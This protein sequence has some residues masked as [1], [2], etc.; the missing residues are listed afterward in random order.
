MDGPRKFKSY[1][2]KYAKEYIEK[3]LLSSSDEVQEQE[4][5]EAKEEEK[6]SLPDFT[7]ANRTALAKHEADPAIVYSD[8]DQTS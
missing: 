7:T 6:E 4:K 2:K 3:E 5:E 1:E 8:E